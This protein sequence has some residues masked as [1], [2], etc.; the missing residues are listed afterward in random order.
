MGELKDNISRKLN[1][2]SRICDCWLEVGSCFCTLKYTTNERKRTD[3]AK[4]QG[5]E[6]RGDSDRNDESNAKPERPL[7]WDARDLET[8]AWI[9]N[10][11]RAVKG[12]YTNRF[13]EE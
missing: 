1:R 8:D 12:E 13:F 4:E 3:T 7:D 2:Q 10:S 9:R 5:E 11:V 6:S